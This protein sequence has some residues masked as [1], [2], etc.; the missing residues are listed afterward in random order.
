[1]K[2]YQWSEL[3]YIAGAARMEGLRY[4]RYVACGMPNLEQFKQRVDSGEYDPLA[5]A[6]RPK[7]GTLAAVAAQ[8]VL[9]EAPQ[10][11]KAPRPEYLIPEGKCLGCG[12]VIPAEYRAGPAKKLCEECRKK[13]RAEQRRAAAKTYLERKRAGT[14]EDRL[15]VSLP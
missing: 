15:S 5:E 13:R 14:E 2:H 6:K 11:R 12:A 9:A 4:G 7:Q 8:D 1:M 3:D 10:K